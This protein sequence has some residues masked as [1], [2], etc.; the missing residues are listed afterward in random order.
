MGSII[1]LYLDYLERTVIGMVLSLL[2]L[3][4]IF[5]FLLGG[6][7]RTPATL[8]A[9]TLGFVL[10]VEIGRG[11]V[12]REHPEFRQGPLGEIRLF[13]LLVL[14]RTSNVA[15]LL[16]RIWRGQISPEAVSRGIAI[17]F[18][19]IAIWVLWSSFSISANMI[20]KRNQAIA[21]ATPRIPATFFDKAITLQVLQISDGDS[22]LSKVTFLISSEGYPDV[23]VESARV[24]YVTPYNG[25]NLFHI[26]VRE[27]QGSTVRFFVER[28]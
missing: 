8:A 27:V 7:G 6:N 13:W 26:E 1:K 4:S 16:S 23:R 25:L 22:P 17:V 20:L 14:R 15:N 2:A 5:G 9:I 28:L 18:L 11:R 12:R 10:I 19:A 21:G 3:I 24:G